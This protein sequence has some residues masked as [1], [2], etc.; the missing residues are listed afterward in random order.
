MSSSFRVISLIQCR[1]IF[2]GVED[3][4]DSDSDNERSD[5]VLSAAEK[6]RAHAKAKRAQAARQPLTPA[7]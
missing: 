2:I 3:D 7:N 6:M 5:C 4:V 1:K